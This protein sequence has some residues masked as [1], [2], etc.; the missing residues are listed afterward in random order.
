MTGAEEVETMD[1]DFNLDRKEI[2]EILRS[3]KR[4]ILVIIDDLL[5]G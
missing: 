2:D 3:L 5:I 1:K 4:P